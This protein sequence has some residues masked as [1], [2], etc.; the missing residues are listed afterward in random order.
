[1]HEFP[2]NLKQEEWVLSQLSHIDILHHC[3]VLHPLYKSF[4]PATVKIQPYCLK[5]LPKHDWLFI[6]KK[7]REEKKNLFQKLN[8]HL[9]S[10]EW[11]LN[12]ICIDERG[13]SSRPRAQRSQTVG[14]AA[15]ADINHVS[16]MLL[17]FESMGR[18]GVRLL[19][20]H[21]LQRPLVDGGLYTQ[22][23]NSPCPEG[24][25]NNTPSIT[26]SR[27]RKRVGNREGKRNN[28]HLFTVTVV[29]FF[30]IFFM[31]YGW[32]REPWGEL[33][34]SG[35]FKKEVLVLVWK[36]PEYTKEVTFSSYCM[37]TCGKTL[38]Q[39]LAAQ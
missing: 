2:K 18:L 15:K 10:L 21:P 7:K 28:K 17:T 4:T 14:G 12:A 16:S 20:E 37:T 5:L 39:N 3:V 30:T 24:S 36:Q 32:L 35:E 13:W 26:K 11:I 33:I 25:T 29:N 23:N 22:V 31:I 38:C 19:Q 6:W 8:Q 27:E 34:G 1:M 9:L